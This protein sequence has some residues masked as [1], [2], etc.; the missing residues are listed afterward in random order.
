[1]T[2]FF[3][4]LL[5]NDRAHACFLNSLSYLEYRGARKIARALRTEDIDPEVLKHAFEESRHALYFKSLALKLGGPDFRR[6]ESHS[7]FAASAVK[8]YFYQLDRMVGRYSP[9][10]KTSYTWTTWLVEERAMEVYSL[11]DRLLAERHSEISLAP[12]LKDEAQH[13]EFVRAGMND[14]ETARLR[15]IEGD[16][17]SSLRGEL[18]RELEART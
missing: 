15:A 3:H 13:L 2:D 9:D 11:Y 10:P 18:W 17:F 12:V 16:L 7:L 4:R 1:M 14:R 8:T 5:G 6:Y